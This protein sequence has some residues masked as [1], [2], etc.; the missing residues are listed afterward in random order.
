MI[1]ANVRATLTRSDVQLAL[2]LLGERGRDAADAAEL[3]LREAGIDGLLDDPALADA[4]RTHDRG[5]AA[6]EA[7]FTY[8]AVRHALR[9]MGEEDRGLA[10]FVSSIL[11][12]FSR[13]RRAQRVAAHDDE[14]FDSL[15]MLAEAM[16]GPDPRRAFLVRVHL[17]EYALWMGGMFPDRIAHLHARRGA[18]GLSY[19]DEMGARG[20]RL[21]AE[22]RL[23]N[24]LGVA[25]LFG[26]TA[27]RFPRLRAALNQVSD[28]LLFPRYHSADR[29]MRQVSDE[30]RWRAA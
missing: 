14:E 15:A 24:E 27:E 28:T 4:L 5:A 1:L 13:G 26:A 16:D 12:H 11:L 17:G 23:A 8:V 6:S 19:F 22:H 25:P 21:A 7:L 18:P 2:A 30:V 9:R 20:F 10:D 3:R 29:L